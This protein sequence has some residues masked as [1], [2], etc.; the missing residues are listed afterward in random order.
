MLVT[1][2]VIVGVAGLVLTGARPLLI[3]RIALPITGLVLCAAWFLI[4]K[5]GLEYMVYYTLSAREL[6]ELYLANSVHTISHG[7]LLGASKEI[8]L[9]LGGRVIKRKMS[10]WA[11]L[12]RAEWVAYLVILA[13]VALYVSLLFQT[14]S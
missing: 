7:A 13:F 12:A 1:N 9:T 2:G 3:L 14:I 11:R 6:E 5:R 10:K 8:S 4:V